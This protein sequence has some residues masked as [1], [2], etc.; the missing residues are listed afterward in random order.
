M[1]LLIYADQRGWLLVPVDDDVEAYEGKTFF[2][3]RV[4]DGDTIELAF[5][6]VH[7]DKPTT[8][9]RL[10]GI[11]CPEVARNGRKAEP[12][13]DEATDF[14]RDRCEGDSV[15]LHLEPQRLRDVYDRLLAYVILSDGEDLSEA[16]LR[17][18]FA[19]ADE[20]WRHSK[21]EAFRRAE[22]EARTKNA[23]LWSGGSGAPAPGTA[24]SN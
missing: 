23:G 2:V 21:V 22:D 10:W 4:I 7:T 5:P 12:W 18:G 19:H 14:A 17:A 16:L 13:A 24:H 6:D 1:A 3:S 15:V 11:D 20:R 9:V 8:H